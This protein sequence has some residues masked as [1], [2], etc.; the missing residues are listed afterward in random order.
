MHFTDNPNYRGDWWRF[1][2]HHEY[3]N[4]I[5]DRVR[6]VGDRLDAGEFETQAD[7]DTAFYEADYDTPP[8]DR[9][10]RALQRNGLFRLANLLM[11]GPE[12]AKAAHANPFY[13]MRRKNM[14]QLEVPL[15]EYIEEDPTGLM[16]LAVDPPRK[17]LFWRSDDALM[18]AVLTGMV[19]TALT[20]N[21]LMQGMI[22]LV[23][24]LKTRLFLRKHPRVLA[25]SQI[26]WQALYVTGE[27]ESEPS[28]VYRTREPWSARPM[29][30]EAEVGPLMFDRVTVSRS[31][32][33][34]LE[35]M[36]SQFSAVKGIT[37]RVTNL[38]WE[39][40]DEF[41]ERFADDFEF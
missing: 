5:Y 1:E 22:Q 37:P 40:Q 36:C 10:H 35:S 30:R 29:S 13:G 38:T 17:G 34:L 39:V 3:P 11:T 18:L 27:G 20:E 19:D 41:E 24:S 14:D 8:G 16:V 6:A 2:D 25:D 31:Y 7:Y 23:P 4:E 28:Y 9:N 15:A 32:K 12:L 21:G 33:V 26:W